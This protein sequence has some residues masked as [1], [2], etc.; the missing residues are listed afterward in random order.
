M[1][2]KMANT[3]TIKSTYTCVCTGVV[4]LSPKSWADVEEFHIKW[5]TLFV[6]FKNETDL[7]EYPVHS[8]ADAV[9]WK[10]PQ[11]TEIY[12]AETEFDDPLYI[13]N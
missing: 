7:K 9:D 3:I 13:S 5:D 11:S 10:R 4:D 2:H 8:N 1:G 12:D 6:Q